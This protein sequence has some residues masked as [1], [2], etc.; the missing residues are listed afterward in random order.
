MIQ[1][2]NNYYQ[3]NKERQIYSNSQLQTSR[4][5]VELKAAY[6]TSDITLGGISFNLIFFL[7]AKVRPKACCKQTQTCA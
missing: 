3:K 2:F 1:S 5:I 4:R 6:E 7:S